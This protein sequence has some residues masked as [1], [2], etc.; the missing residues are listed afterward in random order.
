M[1]K[2]AI[3][4]SFKKLLTPSRCRECD[5]YVYFHGYECGEVSVQ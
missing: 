3:S 5:S 1:S 2:A 4:H